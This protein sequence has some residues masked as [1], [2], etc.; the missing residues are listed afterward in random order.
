VM[1]VETIHALYVAGAMICVRPIKYNM[2]QR[3]KEL[4]HEA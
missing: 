1:T 2:I 4:H 3:Q